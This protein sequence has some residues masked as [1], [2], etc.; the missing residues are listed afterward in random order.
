[1]CFL[2]QSLGKAIYLHKSEAIKIGKCF[3][4]F[5]FI[6]LIFLT[7]SQTPT[8]FLWGSLQYGGY[9]IRVVLEL[10]DSPVSS[11]QLTDEARRHKVNAML[12]FIHRLLQLRYTYRT[13][14]TSQIYSIFS[15][16]TWT[17][18][19]ILK[20]VVVSRQMWITAK[21]LRPSLKNSFF[22]VA[23]PHFLEWVGRLAFFFFFFFFVRW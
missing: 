19:G 12:E 10:G 7:D 9:E 20:G 16:K 14:D 2:S 8:S 18:K 22:A 3:W 6:Q 15:P 1:M 11:L 13:I 23:N 17:D 4:F 21:I 5:K